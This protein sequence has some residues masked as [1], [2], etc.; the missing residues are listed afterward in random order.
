MITIQS[1]QWVDELIILL[2]SFNTGII[3]TLPIKILSKIL[4]VFM[5]RQWIQAGWFLQCVI[6]TQITPNQTLSTRFLPAKKL[7]KISNI[8]L[9]LTCKLERIK[10][11]GN[12][13][14][15]IKKI[16]L[17][18]IYVIINVTTLL[19]FFQLEFDISYWRLFKMNC[20]IY[21]RTLTS[22]MGWVCNNIILLTTFS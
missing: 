21:I 5:Y 11:L 22:K 18:K 15:L 12:I 14:R 13:M 19:I 4:T 3:T 20:L 16:I 2:H 17:S 6:C 10:L 8:S 7:R 9:H 1:P